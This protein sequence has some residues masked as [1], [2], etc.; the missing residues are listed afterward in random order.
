M[1]LSV[2]L[3]FSLRFVVVYSLVFWGQCKNL[4]DLSSPQCFHTK[5]PLSN[6]KTACTHAQK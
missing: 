4:E 3:K 2:L 1:F 6:I 5:I